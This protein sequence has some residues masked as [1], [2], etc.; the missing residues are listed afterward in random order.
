VV[1]ALHAGGRFNRMHCYRNSGERI[2]Q[3]KRCGFIPCG[4]RMDIDLPKQA[5]SPVSVGD[6]VNGGTDLIGEFVH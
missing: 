3:G 5:R 2:G 6:S 1:I 4:T